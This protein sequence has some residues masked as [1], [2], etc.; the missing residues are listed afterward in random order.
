MLVAPGSAAIFGGTGA[1]SGNATRVS[2]AVD[3]KLGFFDCDRMFPIITEVIG[4]GAAGYAGFQQAAQGQSIFVGDVINGTTVAIPSPVDVE[5]MEVAVLPA[6][7]RL[8]RKM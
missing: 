2:L 1:L 4:V 5:G 7:R 8:D 6:H 3:S